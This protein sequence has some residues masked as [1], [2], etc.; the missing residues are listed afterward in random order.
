MDSP[1]WTD[2]A[3][4]RNTTRRLNSF[5]HLIAVTSVTPVNNPE[6]FV[7]DPCSESRPSTDSF[8]NHHRYLPSGLLLI[9]VENRDLIRLSVEEAGVPRPW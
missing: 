2:E 7:G 8:E 3:S 9:V 6:I 5:I 1:I 4:P